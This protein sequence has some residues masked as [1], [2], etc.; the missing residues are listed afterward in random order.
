[1]VLAMLM[2]LTVLGCS[3]RTPEQQR[4]FW[5]QMY[6]Q[7]AR[8]ANT[9]QTPEARAEARNRMERYEYEMNKAHDATI[10]R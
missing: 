9:A 7:A 8:D 5:Q 2:L 1:M 3:E 6:M 10:S 4:E